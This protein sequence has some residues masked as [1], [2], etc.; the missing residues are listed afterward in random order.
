MTRAFE[1]LIIQLLMFLFEHLGGFMSIMS[2]GFL[3][4]LAIVS[5]CLSQTQCVTD[6]SRITICWDIDWNGYPTNASDS[7]T[8]LLYYKDYNSSVDTIWK[9][10]GSTK[11]TEYVVDKLY[12]K[13]VI[14]GVK[15]VLY[16]DTSEIHSSLDPNACALGTCPQCDQQ[17]SW[18][19][20]WKL[21]KAFGIRK[22]K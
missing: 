4:F 12:K 5:V 14:F 8:Y 15:V 10:I 2:K 16:N 20:D 3:C 1:I 7:A 6:S 22:E 13:K 9:E 21:R 19:V 17:G 18:Y 11:Q